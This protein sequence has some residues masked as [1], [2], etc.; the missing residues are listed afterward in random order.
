MSI[1]PRT[2][3]HTVV[4]APIAAAA[5]LMVLISAGGALPSGP[6]AADPPRNL[7]E[8][9]ALSDAATATWLLRSGSDPNAFYE[10][11][12]G[13]LE[14]EV[15]VHVRP[16]AAA[17]YTSD[18]VMVRVAQRYGAR[19]TPEEARAVACR[20]ADKGREEIAR[21]V[22]PSDWTAESCGSAEEH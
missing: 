16:L 6:F 13:L 7:A 9:I 3:L 15:G 17:A 5:G 11:R 21:M 20:M 4:A 1:A 12:P 18:D 19:L 22:A 10:V 8:A 14:S 2:I